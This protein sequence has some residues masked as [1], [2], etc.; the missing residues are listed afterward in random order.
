[1]G[2]SGNDDELPSAPGWYPDPWSATG[3]GERYFDGK[4]WGTSEKPLGRLSTVTELDAHRKRR[5]RKKRTGESRLRGRGPTIIGVIVVVI[6][7]FGLSRLQS[8]SP[9]AQNGKAPT[10]DT[11]TA[12]ALD[13]PPPMRNESK[14]PLG[15]PA[16]VPAGSGKFEVLEDQPGHAASPVA[17]DPCREVHY[18]TNPTGA[19]PDGAAM[20]KNAIARVQTAT[21]LHF[22]DD[23][24]TS[25]TPSKDRLSFQPARYG[26]R[27]APVLI[28]WS[29]EKAY[30]EL[31]G[32]IAGIGSPQSE[33][34]ADDHLVYV[35]GQVI[36][37]RVQMSAQEIPV[38]AEARAIV[39]HELGHLVGLDHTSDRRQIMFSES[40]FNVTN[41]ADGDLRGLSFLGKQPCY[42]GV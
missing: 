14:T 19:P 13:R 9:H 4:H 3:T 31:A 22:V 40:Q 30:P 26:Q 11:L 23:G 21:G 29:D 42:P 41:Y 1:M 7:V 39:L 16:P 24:T 33:Y 38:R 20:V 27:W 15:V 32:Y 17:W 2:K 36:F 35:T 34:T 28:A 10:T 25:E 6:A 18:V 8:G 37:D 12:P 5:G